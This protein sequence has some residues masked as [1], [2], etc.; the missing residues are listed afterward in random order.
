MRL[1]PCALVLVCCSQLTRVDGQLGAFV[2]AGYFTPAPTDGVDHKEQLCPEF[3]LS[4]GFKADLKRFGL[5]VVHSTRS[6]TDRPQQ[7][8]DLVQEDQ[9]TSTVTAGLYGLFPIARKTAARLHWQWGP[10]FDLVFPYRTDVSRTFTDQTSQEEKDAYVENRPPGMR[11]GLRLRGEWRI[12]DQYAPFAQLGLD[13][14]LRQAFTESSDH[15]NSYSVVT[16]PTDR[17]EYHL[18]LGISLEI[19]GSNCDCPAFH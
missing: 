3:G 2:G 4:I 18:W 10:T 6:T 14:T 19:G 17:L 16:P 15:F 13:Y 12:A 7:P 1:R 8:T 11:L 5:V 9:R